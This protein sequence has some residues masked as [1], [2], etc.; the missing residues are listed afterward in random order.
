MFKMFNTKNLDSKKFNVKKLAVPVLGLA[1][2]VPTVAGAAPVQAAG[3]ATNIAATAAQPTMMKATVDTPAVELRAALDNLLSEHYQLAV[4]A[5]IKAYEGTPDAAAA[6]QAL[7]QNAL[8]MLPAIE[9]LYGKAGADEFGRIFRAHNKYTDDLVK[10]TKSGDTAAAKAAEANIEKFVKEFSAFLG[11]ATGGKL[12][13]ATAEKVLRL[14]EDQVQEAFDKYVAGDYTGAYTAYREGLNEMF[15]ISKAL[16]TA[17]VTQM[18]EK[19]QNT[20]ADTPAGDL[21]SALNRLFAEHFALAALQMQEQY[22]GMSASSSALVT[23]EAGNTKD[24]KAAIASVYGSAGADQFEKLWTTDHINVQAQYVAAVKS[25]DQAAIA[26][27]KAQITKFTKEMAA[28][29]SAAT[30]GRIPEAGALEGLT[31]HENQVQQVLDQYAAKNYT[32]S[33]KTEREGYALM[34][35]VGKLL[36]GAIVDQFNSKFQTPSAMPAPQPSQPSMPANP[37]MTTVKMQIGSPNLTLNGKTTKMDTMPRVWNN[38]TYVPLRFLSEGIG[39]QVKWNKKA[40]QVTVM[41]G[42]DTLKFWLGK[43][44]MEVNG[45]R[46]AVGAK[47]FAD[48]NGRTVVPLRFITGL[49]GWD[50]QVNSSN[51]MITLTKS[52]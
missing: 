46:Q 41:A 38:T 16:S 24:F 18:P 3:A 48:E 52:M 26:A 11:T 21:R 43:D 2:V 42:N 27:A 5:M 7:D 28:F 1:L 13:Q 37:S 14:H 17:I 45:K 23:A 19:F 20:K 12:P 8:D 35:D 29:L 39:A 33:Y 40:N 9:S 15:T 47:V 30:E 25:G 22:D 6:Y 4:D 50:F 32:G 34:F 36:S 31:A 51:W 44:F 10:A 49:L